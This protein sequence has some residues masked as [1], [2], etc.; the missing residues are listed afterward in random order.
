MAGGAPFIGLAGRAWIGDASMLP[1]GDQEQIYPVL[2]QRHLHPV[3]F[4]V[5]IASIL[6]I[7]VPELFRELQEYRMLAFGGGMVLVMVWRP[8][9]LLAHRDPTV[10]L[11][12]GRRSKAARP[13]EGRA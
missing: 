6:L 1:G 2:A 5:V 4:G 11:F 9:G 8:R 10:R 13:S 3:L 12:K 7:G